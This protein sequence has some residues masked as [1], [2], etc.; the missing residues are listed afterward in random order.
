MSLHARV[1][2]VDD[3]AGELTQALKKLEI[4]HQRGALDRDQQADFLGD[5]RKAVELHD[6]RPMRNRAVLDLVA[7]ALVLVF[8]AVMIHRGTGFRHL[9]LWAALFLAVM[10]LS[11]G[12][13]AW[14]F[15][16]YLRRRRHDRRWLANLDAAVS[17]GGT[18]FET[19]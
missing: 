10:T 14:R 2:R 15:N 7:G 3:Y 13:A 9:N 16:L 17:A 5:L 8:G 19:H 18:I 11:L 6:L 4:E 1:S 12:M